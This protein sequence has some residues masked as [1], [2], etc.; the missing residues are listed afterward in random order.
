MLC[1]LLQWNVIMEYTTKFH[2]SVPTVGCEHLFTITNYHAFSIT[3][4]YNVCLR[5]FNNS[6]NSL[7]HKYIRLHTMCVYAHLLTVKTFSITNTY[8][9]C[10]RTFINSKNSLHHKYIRLHTMCVYAHLLTVKTFSITN[11]YKYIQCVFTHIY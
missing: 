10:L 4:T 11:T 5:T 3:T 7:H 6:K 8:N 9:V 1:I 2:Y